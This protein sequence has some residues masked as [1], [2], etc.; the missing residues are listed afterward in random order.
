MNKKRH[1]GGF[2]QLVILVV[3]AVVLAAGVLALDR[4]NAGARDMLTVETRG[5]QVVSALTKYRLENGSY[6]DDLGKLVPKFAT[7]LGTCPTGGAIEYHLS[8][9]DYV[10]SCDKVVFKMQPY[11]YDSRTRLWSS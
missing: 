11:R 9:N 5:M 6:P 3:V 4:Y 10:L 2:A 8:G 1:S 7:A